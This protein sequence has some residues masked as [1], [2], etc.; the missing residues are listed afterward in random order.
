MTER[1]DL[2]HTKA[3]L[4]EP[5]FK[6]NTY[7]FIVTAEGARLFDALMEKEGRPERAKPIKVWRVFNHAGE[8]VFE[9]E[10]YTACL[11]FISGERSGGSFA[12]RRDPPEE[13][14]P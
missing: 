12:I 4:E 13:A 7:R 10:W 8:V 14:Q 2:S 3:L 1:P 5:P 6:P 11:T 9:S